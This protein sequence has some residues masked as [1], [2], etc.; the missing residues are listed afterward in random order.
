MQY[1]HERDLHKSVTELTERLTTLEKIKDNESFHSTKIYH[2]YN[3]NP[4]TGSYTA[5]GQQLA[6]EL[7]EIT[8]GSRRSTL[9]KH[10]TPGDYVRYGS[11]AEG[12]YNSLGRQRRSQSVSG[13]ARGR[14]WVVP[15]APLLSCASRCA[16]S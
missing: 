10:Y 13:L 3:Q 6:Q 5:T 1:I 11:E 9:R 2:V 15:S 14:C 16:P 4:E 7:D 8:S 12:G